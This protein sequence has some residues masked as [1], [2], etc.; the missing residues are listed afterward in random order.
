M[1]LTLRVC[2][3]YLSQNKQL[4]LA[5]TYNINRLVFFN[6]GGEFTARYALGAYMKQMHIIFEGI[7]I[8]FVHCVMIQDVCQ[9]HVSPDDSYIRTHKISYYFLAFY[10]SLLILWLQSVLLWT[11]RPF[12]VNWLWG[13]GFC[14]VKI[15]WSPILCP[16]REIYFQYPTYIQNN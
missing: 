11:S 14:H 13:R 3:L 6:V 9:L 12:W 7:M 4:L 10:S 8:C 2:V 5:C 15:Q 1:V 16:W